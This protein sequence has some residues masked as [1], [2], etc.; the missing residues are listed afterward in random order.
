MKNRK[1]WNLFFILAGIVVG[2]FVA[3]LCQNV[4]LLSWLAYGITFGLRAPLELD[5]YIIQLSVQISINL[6]LS[7]VIFVILSLIIGRA[8]KK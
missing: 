1:L 2:T 4:R 5:L 8:I 3:E 6:T 7:V